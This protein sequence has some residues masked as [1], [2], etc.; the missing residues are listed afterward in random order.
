MPQASIVSF[1]QCSSR[2]VADFTRFYR[3][4]TADSL[5]FID[6]VV[7]GP[8]IVV[9][10]DE[11]KLGKRKY[12]R[13]HYVG[14]VWVLGRVERTE[15]RKAFLVTVP[16]RGGRTLMNVLSRHILPGSVILTDLWRGYSALAETLGVEHRTVNH[17]ETFVN[18]IDGTCTNTIEGTW[19]GVKLSMSARK[20]TGELAQDCLW[21]FIWRRK[22]HDDLWSGLLKSLSDVDYGQ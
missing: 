7:G 5:D 9:E 4:A 22:H 6:F 1:A 13:G 3:Q 8:G 20:R 2:T 10:V 21:E 19:N 12:N 17:S 11:C 18:P 14:G 16:D 15:S